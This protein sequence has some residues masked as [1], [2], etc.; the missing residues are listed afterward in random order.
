V[1]RE[2]ET[3]AES[4]RSKLFNTIDFAYRKVAIKRPLKAKLVISEARIE[5]LAENKTF[6]KLNAE[7]QAAWIDFFREHLGEENYDWAHQQVKAHNRT[8]GF[9]KTS[10]ALGN[11]FV[12]VF[13]ERDENA[14]IVRDDKGNAVADTRLNDSESV[15]Y[16]TRVEAYFKTEVLPHVPDA[17]IDDSV[18]DGKDGEVGIVG[19][20]INFN[21]YFY[22]YVPPRPL[23]EIDADLK[24][25]EAWIQALLKEVAE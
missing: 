8:D 19:Y 13:I 15:P 17:Y 16:G 3:F 24:A 12:T 1:V 6:Q 23:H 18:R 5:T 25:A 11:A 20:E 10:K 9:G 14:D 4:E 7:Q 22:Q 21:R 2:Y